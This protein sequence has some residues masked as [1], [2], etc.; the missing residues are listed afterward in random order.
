MQEILTDKRRY[1]QH[2]EK[3]EQNA[4]VSKVAKCANDVPSIPMPPE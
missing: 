4:V 1:K 3:K 2:T